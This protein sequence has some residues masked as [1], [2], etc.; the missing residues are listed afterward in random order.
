MTRMRLV[1]KNV[2][3]MFFSKSWDELR[4]FKVCSQRTVAG[5]H[6]CSQ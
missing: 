4:K 2:G 6:T 1:D 5:L 3:E